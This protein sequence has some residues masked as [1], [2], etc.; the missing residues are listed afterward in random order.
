VN[1]LLKR[2]RDSK[3]GVAEVIGSLVII[4]IV[5][6]AGTIVYAYSVNVIGS[7]S[8]NFN[9][10]TTQNEELLQERFEIIKVW[11]N[12]NQLNLT[13]F[14]YGQTDLSIV[15]VYINGTAVPQFTSG[16]TVKIGEG[17]LLNVKFT[18]PFFVQS[19]SCLEILAISARGGRNTVFYQ[20]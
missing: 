3:K 18:S 16:N 8:S 12:Q 13:L 11:S 15:A 6:I 7:S 17:Q 5:A 10:Q 20:A 4:L 9:L 19:G 14:N 1:I 2:L